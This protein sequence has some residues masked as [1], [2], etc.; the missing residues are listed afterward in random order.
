MD[1]VTLSSDLQ[2]QFSALQMTQPTVLFGLNSVANVL[3]TQL[4]TLPFKLVYPFFFVLI[5]SFNF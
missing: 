2:C 3:D 5:T 4:D 1:L